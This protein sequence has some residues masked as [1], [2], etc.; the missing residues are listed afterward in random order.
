M[1]EE[2][3][4]PLPDSARYWNRLGIDRC[5]LSLDRESLDRIVCAHQCAI[6][7]ENL[8]A[9]DY[10]TPISLGIGDLFEKIILGRRGG[11]CFELNALFAALLADTGFTVVPC[12]ARSLKN[13]GYIQPVAH[14]GTIVALGEERV[15]CD[16]GYGGPMSA[17]AL[18]LEDGAEISSCGQTFLVERMEDPWWRILYC[19]RASLDGVIASGSSAELG[20][21]PV[22]AF[23]DA[24]QHEVDFVALSLYCSTHPSSIFTQ[25]RM[26][27]RRTEEG[28]A[29]IIADRFVRTAQG[30]KEQRIIGSEDEFHAL[31]EQHFG[32]VAPRKSWS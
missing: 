15:F 4:E 19:G 26:I 1:F 3:Y 13:K 11:Y 10:R 16:V 31:L 18:P 21:E 22:L 9:C 27:N 5:R 25:Q 23:M 8:D 24:A 17:C 30:A 7:F 20:P 29:S 32:I 28:S 6:P 14:R 12:F 2:L